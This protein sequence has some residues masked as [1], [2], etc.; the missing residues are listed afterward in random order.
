MFTRDLSE[1]RFS[2][3][4]Q[5]FLLGDQRTHADTPSA[6]RKSATSG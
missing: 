1:R 2:G 3:H 5:L 4:G 6:V